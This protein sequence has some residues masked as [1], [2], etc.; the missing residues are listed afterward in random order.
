MTPIDSTDAGDRPVVTT[1]PRSMLSRSLFF[2]HLPSA[3]GALP[4]I[5]NYS[6]KN[7]PHFSSVVFNNSSLILVVRGNSSIQ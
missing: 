1:A 5:F 6:L 2:A 7:F 4:A 3:L